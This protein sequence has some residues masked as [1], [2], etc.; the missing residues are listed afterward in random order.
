MSQTART[1][2]LIPVVRPAGD[3]GPASEKFRDEYIKHH[4]AAGWETHSRSVSRLWGEIRTAIGSLMPLYI[5]MRLYQEGL[6]EC[7]RELQIVQEQA[8]QGSKDHELLLDLIGQGA[9]L[10]GTEDP[11]HL[12]PHSPPKDGQARRDASAKRDRHIAERINVTLQPGEIGVLLLGPARQVQALL[13]SDI[14][15]KKVM[16]LPSQSW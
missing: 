1:L 10:M 14:I 12:R 13:A 6:P 16:S 5:G 15:V 7:G 11:Q 3:T 4:G 2:L 8:A 9:L